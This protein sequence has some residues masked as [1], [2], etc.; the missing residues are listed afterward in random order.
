MPWWIATLLYAM[1]WFFE[2]GAE[3][4]IQICNNRKNGY[5]LITNSWF[6]IEIAIFYMVFFLSFN[7]CVGDFRKGIIKSLVGV[8]LFMVLAYAVGLGGWWFYSSL[9]FVLGMV[10]KENETNI[11]QFSEKKWFLF[12]ARWGIIFA[13]GYAVRFLNSRTVHSPVIYDLALLISSFGFTGI[14]FSILKKIS[15]NSY[16][17]DFIGRV[18]FELYLIHELIYNILRNEKL[19]LY[20]ENDLLYVSLVVF[21]SVVCAYIF[22]KIITKKLFHRY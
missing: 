21:L 4:V 18:S 3:R 11:N 20:V 14:V 5:L 16:L 22:N 19:G 13:F 6:V 1:Y 2:G 8:C 15:I 12:I 7:W 10:W 9:T 17:W